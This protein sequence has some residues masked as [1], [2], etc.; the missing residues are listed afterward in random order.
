MDKD[1]LK[2]LR[3]AKKIIFIAWII[4]AVGSFIPLYYRVFLANEIVEVPLWA[5]APFFV[6]S[7][8]I[9]IGLIKG[10]RG[11]GIPLDAGRFFALLLGYQS[12]I[13]FLV[14]VTNMYEIP[15]IYYKLIW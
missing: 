2:K 14:Y 6:V 13:P 10:S 1:S 15:F 4:A 3:S 11:V 7:I 8:L 9:L 5:T 12:W